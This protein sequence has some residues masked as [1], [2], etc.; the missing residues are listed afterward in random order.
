MAIKKYIA[1]AD[2]TIT[3]AYQNDLETRG[4]GANTGEADILDVFSIYGRQ[5]TSSAELSRILVK[6]PV[7]SITTDRSNG[8]IPASGS[9]N[10]YLKMYNAPHSKTV[11]D[12]YTITILAVSQSWQEGDG[13]DL[14]SFKDVTYGNNGSNWMSGSNTANV[15]A[16][17][18]LTA[19]SKT[20]GEANTRT[21]IVTDVEG[22][23]VTFA[24][25]NSLT[26]S[27]AT[28]IAFGNANSNATQFATNIAAA[29]NAASTAGTL[30]ITATASSATVTLTMTSTSIAGNRVTNIV[31]TAITDSVV[32]AASQWSASTPTVGY[33]TDIHGT[34]LAGG[35]YHTS[36]IKAA[37]PNS[38]DQEQHIFNK[39]FTSGLEDLEIKITP[40]VEQW[41][42]GTYS[43]YGVGVHLSASYE[44]YS[45]GA[46]DGSHPRTPG[47][48]YPVTDSNTG[49]D[50]VIYNPSGSTVSYYIKRFFGRGSQY[51]FKRPTIEAR[52]DDSRRDNRGSF[53]YSSSLAD[54]Y[55]N[56]NTIYFYNYVRG[57]LKDLPNFGP[58]SGYKKEIYVSIF[59][60]NLDNDNI[61]SS[62]GGYA[63][64]ACQ[65]LSVDSDYVNAGFLLVAT[66]GIVST[67]I[68]SASFAFTGASALTRLY[69][70]W[71]TGSLNT[72][73]AFSSTATRF[74]TGSIIPYTLN[75]SEIKTRPS[76]YMN[77]T[78]LRDKYR[79]NETA[80]L[81]L[82]VRE[83]GWSP[84]IYSKAT[85]EIKTI[86]VQSASYRLFRVID[87][88][89]CVPY[90]T[91]S[92][93]HTALSYDVSGNYFDFD[94]SLLEAG[95]EY[96][97][98]FAFYDN[99]LSSWKEQPYVFKF[100]VED[101]EY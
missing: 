8:D 41:L 6:F 51:F 13:L 69:D 35:S 58:A 96:G 70:V 9:V 36:S 10:F 101:Y 39:T 87:G 47:E 24:I 56:M 55:D 68:Y 26:T 80:R 93:M 91:G 30:N 40:L 19:L 57:A 65:A 50:G 77:I 5:S 63:S 2:N 73:A 66:G 7:E 33:W 32:T 97:F 31:G 76:Y 23:A 84:T 25:D 44:A 71:F 46:A 49:R 20:S 3:N 90:G 11:P 34:V 82:Y 21:L 48:V 92:D 62:A 72:L 14:E 16:S 94:M 38:F 54:R 61:S 64:G 45:S 85:E 88:Y 86:N 18:T 95:Y 43:N 17:A 28:K 29:V 22:N 15:G 59:S 12:D 37:D 60:G 74:F 42:A 53:F 75:A 67:G 99:T 100:R 79:N 81:Q 4:T 83:K 27:T 52:W 98:K 78:N 1:D 89:E